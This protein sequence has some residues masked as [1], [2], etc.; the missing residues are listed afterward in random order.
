MLESLGNIGDFIGGI[1]VVITLLYLAVQ[2]RQNTRSTRTQSWQAAVAAASDWSREVGMN[3]DSC[4]IISQ[5]SLDW[6]SLSDIERVQFNLIMN[7]FLRNCENFHYQYINGTIDESTWSGWAQRT[8]AVLDP[9]GARAWWEA[10]R[11]AYSPEFQQFLREAR[12]AG[13][14][15][16]TLVKQSSYSPERSTEFEQNR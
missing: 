14:L 16:E 4:R 11:T 7:S 3:P 5:G 1:A 2:I 15:P 12:P 9:P 10:A 6:G 8:I 13:P